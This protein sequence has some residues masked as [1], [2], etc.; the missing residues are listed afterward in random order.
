MTKKLEDP[1][2]ACP[3]E[4]QNRGQN[5]KRSADVVPRIKCRW[6]LLLCTRQATKQR[7]AIQSDNEKSANESQ[8]EAEEMRAQVW[9]A[10]V[11]RLE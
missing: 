6:P 10:V 8:G 11:S 2:V 4:K 9:L 5:D 7:W 3:L 1:E